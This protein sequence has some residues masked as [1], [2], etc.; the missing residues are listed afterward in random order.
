MNAMISETVLRVTLRIE[1]WEIMIPPDGSFH[2]A[3]F[4]PRLVAL[5]GEAG[6]LALQFTGKL[7][8]NNVC[9]PQTEVARLCCL[10]V[11]ARCFGVVHFESSANR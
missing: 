3:N 4:S 6:D 7:H 9:R 1:V 2:L 8:M 11:C 10:R 5:G